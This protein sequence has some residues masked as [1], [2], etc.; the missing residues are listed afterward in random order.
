MPHARAILAH[1]AAEMRWRCL[2]LAADFDRVQRAEGGAELLES[3]NTIARLREALQL[4]LADEPNR[5]EAVQLIF[6]DLTPP[7]IVDR[8][9]PTLT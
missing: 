9:P 6:S 8:R 4:L 1:H 2:S 7:P 3:D 5:A